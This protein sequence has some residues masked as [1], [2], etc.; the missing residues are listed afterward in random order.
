MWAE[1]IIIIFFEGLGGG[2]GGGGGVGGW[3]GK[4]ELQFHVFKLI[5]WNFWAG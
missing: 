1:I 4:E 5:F 2:G 3:V